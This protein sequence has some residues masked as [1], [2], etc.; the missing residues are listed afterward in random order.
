MIEKASARFDA[1]KGRIDDRGILS[2]TPVA[3]RNLFT[4]TPHPSKDPVQRHRELLVE[5][6]RIILPRVNELKEMASRVAAT[7]SEK[8]VNLKRHA[9]IMRQ[10]NE[11]AN[12]IRTSR[13]IFA[14]E[15]Q[16]AAL[17]EL[18][19]HVY[20][21]EREFAKGVQAVL[22]S[23]S[24][25]S[26]AWGIA[27]AEAAALMLDG[28]LNFYDAEV[29]MTLS[30]LEALAR[31]LNQLAKYR[32]AAA[33]WEGVRAWKD[34]VKEELL[35]RGKHRRAFIAVNVANGVTSRRTAPPH[36]HDGAMT[37][38]SVGVS[39]RIYVPQRKY[40][41]PNPLDQLD[42]EIARIVNECPLTI[43]VSPVRAG[44]LFPSVSKS[45]KSSGFVAQGKYVF[46]EALPKVCYCRLLANNAVVVRIGGGW[47]E[48]SAFLLN[49]STLEHRIPTV[50]S[51]VDYDPLDDPK[52]PARSLTTPI[53]T[54][55]PVNP[56]SPTP[57]T[58]SSSSDISS[59]SRGSRIPVSKRTI[60]R[61]TVVKVDP[62]E[63]IN[64]YALTPRVAT[65]LMK[66]GSTK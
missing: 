66:F 37:S 9:E 55:I 16:T 24:S 57:S 15:A 11:L 31:S 50:R 12:N 61:A 63:A 34:G 8:V 64:P 25:E 10:L 40:Y 49:H 18:V 28:R 38:P 29:R 4:P 2:P 58:S 43:K 5:L 60:M 30:K 51:F 20:N 33:K 6:E 39:P 46:G 14:K 62:K 52:D 32:D 1:T 3:G 48:L 59:D 17:D 54:V 7:D 36:L 35:Q 21:M 23:A 45:S 65:L 19:E 53:P 56:V 47:Q 44:V 41:T 42:V 26:A 13:E 27:D 22:N